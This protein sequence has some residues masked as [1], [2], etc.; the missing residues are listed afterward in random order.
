MRSFRG[1]N[2]V[3]CRCLIRYRYARTIVVRGFSSHFE[4]FAP[5]VTAAAIRDGR[6][7][8]MADKRASRRQAQCLRFRFAL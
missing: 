8:D 5:G 7:D 6:K 1:R 4:R 3:Y 2:R